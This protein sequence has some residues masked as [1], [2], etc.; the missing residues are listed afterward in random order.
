MNKQ[1]GRISTLNAAIGSTP[2]SE[3]GNS[4]RWHNPNIFKIAVALVIAL[5]IWASILSAVVFTMQNEI[6]SGRRQIR[7]LSSEFLELREKCCTADLISRPLKFSVETDYALEKP[8]LVG[9]NDDYG[10]LQKI[11]GFDMKDGDL[12]KSKGF[13]YDLNDANRYDDGDP[14]EVKGYDHRAQQ[15]ED[16]R[17]KR[18]DGHEL[19]SDTQAGQEPP[20]RRFQ[21]IIS[22]GVFTT[23]REK[24]VGPNIERQKENRT[25]VIF[26]SWKENCT[27]PPGPA[28]PPGPVG[29]PGSKGEPGKEGPTGLPGR[30][31]DPGPP[32]APGTKGNSGKKK[33]RKGSPGKVGPAGRPIRKGKAVRAGPQGLPGRDGDPRL[34][35]AQRT[36]GHPGPKGDKGEPA[37]GGGLSTAAAHFVGDREEGGAIQVEADGTINFW[38][39]ADWMDESDMHKFAKNADGEITVQE[40]G[41]YYVYSQVTYSGNP[42]LAQYIKVDGVMIFRCSNYIHG[43]KPQLSSCYTGGLADLKT[44]SKVEI[45][46]HFESEVQRSPQTTYFGLIKI[47]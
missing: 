32:G 34:Q 47:Q 22:R 18:E 38:K 16:H 6:A 13:D 24:S 43:S 20:T 37:V 40:A 21:E 10:D 45:V 8:Q 27:G 33:D 31:G 25:G 39:F 44:E 11:K 41:L 5:S 23:I 46:V 19:L 26:K 29:F 3:Q 17:Q 35:S 28:G 15:V 1:S 12:R 4:Q 7:Q 30:D 42:F 14:R 9:D 2:K 36:Q